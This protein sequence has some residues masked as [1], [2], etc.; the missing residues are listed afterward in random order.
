MNGFFSGIMVLLYMTSHFLAEPVFLTAT[1]FPS[2]FPIVVMI[3]LHFGP[4]G[5]VI[6]T[7]RKTR[8]FMKGAVISGDGRKLYYD[9]CIRK[10]PP[11]LR[12]AY[13]G[14]LEGE[15]SPQ[16]FTDRVTASLKDRRKFFLAVYYGSATSLSLLTFLVFYFVSTLSETLL[17]T[18]I[19]A[20]VALSNGTVL[21]F[22][23]H[24]YDSSARKSAAKLAELLDARLLREKREDPRPVVERESPCAQTDRLRALLREVEGYAEDA[25]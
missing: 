22:L 10:A 4:C 20:F 6:R 18:V 8:R 23:L 1:A 9:R 21:R 7:A 12:L 19:T 11:A 5:R 15:L 17:R 25:R 3:F 16:G 2:L 14:F 13:G 24:G